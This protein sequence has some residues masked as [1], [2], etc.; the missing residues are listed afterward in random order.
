M[1][2]VPPEE[3][4]KAVED[5]FEHERPVRRRRLLL[6]M[7]RLHSGLRPSEIAQR[8]SRTRSAVTMAAKQ[9]EEEARSNRKL[10]AGLRAVARAIGH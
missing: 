8:Y 9:L 1:A 4:E 5:V 2:R 6:Y 3:V 10:A 7:Q